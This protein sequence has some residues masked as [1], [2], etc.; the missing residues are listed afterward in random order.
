MLAGP[1]HLRL[2]GI[3]AGKQYIS[4]PDLTVGKVDFFE[5]AGTEPAD[6]EAATFVN[7]IL[8]RGE[9]YVTA[10]QAAVVTRILEGI[11]ISDKTGAPYY[12]N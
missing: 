11:Y 5:G 2:N 7:A 3:K 12:F 1:G 9:L 10:E 4:I 6:L 8:G